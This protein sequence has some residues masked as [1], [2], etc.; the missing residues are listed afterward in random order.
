M[1]RVLMKFADGGSEAAPERRGFESLFRPG[2]SYLSLLV[3]RKVTQRKHPPASAAAPKRGNP[4]GGRARDRAV[5]ASCRTSLD[6]PSMA[7]RSLRPATPRALLQGPRKSVPPSFFSSIEIQRR[8]R[9]SD[10]SVPLSLPA[11]PPGFHEPF[12][13]AAFRGPCSSAVRR[14]AHSGRFAMDGE[15]SV[16]GQDAHQRDPST[17]LRAGTAASAAARI[18]GCAFSCLLLFAQA[19][20]SKS[21]IKGETKPASPTK[22]PRRR[23]ARQ[24]VRSDEGD[25]QLLSSE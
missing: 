5:A 20:R 18:P 12:H 3:Q 2:A 22:D 17:I 16:A 10:F 21:P 14:F 24:S 9:K 13:A 7:N 8:A 23:P 6:S 1:S 19:K 11:A 4:R 15:S 25:M